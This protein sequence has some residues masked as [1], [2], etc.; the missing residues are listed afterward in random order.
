MIDQGRP[1]AWSAAGDDSYY[2][3]IGEDIVFELRGGWVGHRVRAR[4]LRAWRGRSRSRCSRSPPSMTTS[5][6]GQINL[7]GN[8]LG[9][10]RFSAMRASTFLDG[11]G[12]RQRHAG[13]RRWRRYPSTGGGGQDRLIGGAGN[14][15]FVF[16]HLTDSV[17]DTYRADGKSKSLPDVILDFTPGQDKINL[18]PIDAIASTPGNRR[19]HLHRQRRLQPS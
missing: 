19:I 1:T 12:G 11:R 5:L 10:R 4:D 13:R 14:D 9:Q 16:D 7:T 15:T 6:R 2:V 17:M 3:E 18:S 8:D